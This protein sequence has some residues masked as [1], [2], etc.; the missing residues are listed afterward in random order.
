MTAAAATT[1]TMRRTKQV[2]CKG[3]M[4][5]NGSALTQQQWSRVA[6]CENYALRGRRKE[7]EEGRNEKHK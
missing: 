1:T 2:M 4:L 5:T 7:G 3:R 6:F